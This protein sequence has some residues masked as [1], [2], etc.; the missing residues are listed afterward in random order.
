MSTLKFEYQIELA[1]NYSKIT[2]GY[3][4]DEIVVK[5]EPFREKLD[6][7][8]AFLE[9]N[10]SAGLLHVSPD[11]DDTDCK[12]VSVYIKTDNGSLVEVECVHCTVCNNITI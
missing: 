12:Y 6:E 9:Q 3:E 10:Y 5:A 4:V 1:R 8:T 11:I 7:I 2:G